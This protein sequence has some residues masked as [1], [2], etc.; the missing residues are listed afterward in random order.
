MQI[1]ELLGST[2]STA[3]VQQV[4]LTS[5]KDAFAKHL[6]DVMSHRDNMRTEEAKVRALKQDDRSEARPDRIDRPE[7]EEQVEAADPE[8]A[9]DSDTQEENAVSTKGNEKSTDA[10]GSETKVATPGM[11]IVKSLE[12][13]MKP[14]VALEA[15][16]KSEISEDT[17][18][19]HAASDVLEEVVAEDASGIVAALD[20]ANKASQ[21]AAINS[22]AK[23]ADSEKMSEKAG[24][25][26]SAAN[27]DTLDPAAAAVTPDDAINKVSGLAMEVAAK[28]D[29]A[30]LSDDV[31][32]ISQAAVQSSTQQTNVPAVKGQERAQSVEKG[33]VEQVVAES[34]LI[35]DAKIAVGPDPRLTEMQ[36]AQA[37]V[38][39]AAAEKIHAQFMVGTGPTNNMA[40]FN[41]VA[42]VQSSG[43]LETAAPAGLQAAQNK[44]T[45]PVRLPENEGMGQLAD[46][47]A[48][49]EA[50]PK[51][52]IQI[53]QPVP[54]QNGLA[55]MDGS[56]QASMSER[57]ANTLAQL[58]AQA[59][60]ATQAAQGQNGSK[61]SQAALPAAVAGA[62]AVG[63]AMNNSATTAPSAAI[64][65]VGAPTGTQMANAA[66]PATPPP[67]PTQ[68][69][70]QAQVAM[71]I[72]KAMQNGADKISIRLNPSE[73][74][75]VDIKLEIARDGAVT[76]SVTVER[77]E[78]LELLKGD[79][80]SLERALANAGL[81]PDSD[82]LSFNLRDQNN[83]G[84]SFAKNADGDG[85]G[86]GQSQDGNNSANGEEND[87]DVEALLAEARASASHDRALDINV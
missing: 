18:I 24:P 66:K 2:A 28:T 81:D 46:A 1:L 51:P 37:L 57:A 14:D 69:P 10:S 7:H 49:P 75:R 26:K 71:H 25:F 45:G 60:Q 80:R 30:D 5:Q 4:D 11:E 44:P 64:A 29:M 74:G 82:K 58:T 39:E 76:A 68:Q 19:G 70:P 77:P 48:K 21:A 65:E 41:Q 32:V 50:A 72:A 67:P 40:A 38:E 73:L 43:A 22:N 42:S 78:T 79:A 17:I 8:E 16:M 63:N 83:S 23:A 6:N 86:T 55:N 13:G 27:A 31:Q 33:K 61:P 36:I 84:N 34:P 3:K 85:K 52:A 20:M 54:G 62:E 59:T 56:A 47:V 9:P 53:A 87:L 12:A 35:K 15:T